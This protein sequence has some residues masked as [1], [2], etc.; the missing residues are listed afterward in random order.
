[1]PHR[2]CRTH[3]RM[4]L[5]L[6]HNILLGRLTHPET[7]V[8]SKAEKCYRGPK[9][10]ADPPLGARR[11]FCEQ[12]RMVRTTREHS[13]FTLWK[14]DINET[15][16]EVARPLYIGY[17]NIMNVV[18]MP[19]ILVLHVGVSGHNVPCHCDC[20]FPRGSYHAH[21]RARQVCGALLPGLDVWRAFATPPSKTKKPP[22]V[23]Q[24]DHVYTPPYIH[25]MW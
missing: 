24:C 18:A 25:I 10:S 4:R 5:L 2:K 22:T 1:M 19:T 21:L 16:K 7:N 20:M 15:T 23:P 13:I 12:T 9:A 17:I 6:V 8:A 14:A 11:P 3:L